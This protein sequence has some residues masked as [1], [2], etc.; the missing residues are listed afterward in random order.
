MF[1]NI[2][3]EKQKIINVPLIFFEQRQMNLSKTKYWCFFVLFFFAINL[4]TIQ[5]ILD[6]YFVGLATKHNTIHICLMKH[7]ARKFVLKRSLYKY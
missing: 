6:Q 5:V 2:T 7:P 4:A 1:P 3:F